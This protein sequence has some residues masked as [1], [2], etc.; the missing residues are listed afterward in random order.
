MKTLAVLIFSSILFSANL[1][2]APPPGA[3]IMELLSAGPTKAK[4]RYNG[5]IITVRKCFRCAREAGVMMG[6][7]SVELLELQPCIRR[8]VLAIIDKGEILSLSCG[9]KTAPILVIPDKFLK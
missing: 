2:A 7:F 9:E 5:E 3:A 6:M 8:L 4:V 1:H